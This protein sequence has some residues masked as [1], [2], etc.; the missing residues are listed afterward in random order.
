[1]LKTKNLLII[2][3]LLLTAV[4]TEYQLGKQPTPLNIST[5]PSQATI[6]AAAAQP[7]PA[8]SASATN[9]EGFKPSP[10]DKGTILQ[11]TDPRAV[12]AFLQ[13]N[14]LST[15]DLI[16]GT[17]QS[18]MVK[19]PL[20]QLQLV[21]G[22]NA[23]PDRQYHALLTP[24][25]PKYSQQWH[26]P[27]VAAPAAWN[28]TTGI[29]PTIVAV[30][31]TGFAL[32]QEDL[33]SQWAP[34]GYDFVCNKNTPQ[35][36]DNDCDSNPTSAAATHGTMTAGLA[37][38]AT[39]NSVGTASL[40]WNVKILP[41]QALG[42][43]GSGN[44]ADVAAAVDYAVNH[45]AKVISMSLGS[46]SIDYFLRQRI[47]AAISAGVTVVAAAGNC[48]DPT[49]YTLNGC[50]YVGQI[51]DPGG[52][53]PVIGVGATDSNDNRASFSSYGPGVAVTAPG[54]NIYSTAWSSNNQTTYYASGSGTSFATPIVASEAALL[55]STLPNAT[56][57][58]IKNDIETGADKVAGMAGQNRTDQYGYGRL[59]AASSLSIYSYSFNALNA[60]T[61]S[62]KTTAVNLGQLSPGGTA[63]ISAQVT[64][65]GSVTWQKTGY[66]VRLGTDMPEDHASPYATNNWLSPNRAATFDETS[67]APGGT[68]TFEFPITTPAG[69]GDVSEHF[70]L[71]ADGLKWLPDTGVT[72]SFHVNSGY[73]LSFDSQYAK[74]INGNPLTQAD[75]NNLNRGQRFTFGI[76]VKNTGTAAWYNNGTYVTRLGTARPH[77]HTG[78]F[79][80][81]S[82]L[83][84]N[85]VVSVK[86]TNGGS[87]VQPGE[88]GV[89]EGTF[90]A[91]ATAGSY[92]EYLLPVVDGITWMNDVGISIPTR[93]H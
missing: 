37:G 14:N 46:S 93:V 81:A 1:M 6:Q 7:A 56:P 49:T 66:P 26:L 65:T 67:V 75:L 55:R 13:K 27:K 48:G 38:A 16:A 18:Y 52:Y 61:D 12:N 53:A 51:L 30:I 74:D 83:S 9:P 59:N 39:N 40:D 23:F 62:A 21:G 60:F 78:I 41:L 43:D 25:D 82:W 69:A 72:V 84:A 42:D 28:I 17:A 36:G 47:D 54:V 34:G 2:I 45:G 90:T 76:R 73:S 58:E 11:F 44:T 29:N 85:R 87:S 5:S 8:P 32:N 68:A 89:F 3:F 80:D 31:D 20:T 70:N 4:F 91:P 77:D 57:A 92:N 10:S 79:L 22:V 88:V 33:A 63:W 35:A 86:N 64:N 71:V 15:G 50:S 19:K 24:N